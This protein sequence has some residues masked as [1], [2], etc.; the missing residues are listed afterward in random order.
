MDDGSETSQLY[1]VNLSAAPTFNPVQVDTAAMGGSIF[2]SVFTGTSDDGIGWLGQLDSTSS[3]TVE[4]AALSNLANVVSLD[5]S[6]PANT[7]EVDELY[8]SSDNR[9]LLIQGELDTAN[10]NELFVVDTDNPAA[11]VKVHPAIT[12]PKDVDGAAIE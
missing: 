7:T 8:L 12:A 6:L 3:V 10:V 2:G 11:P 4:W 9:R 5:G 1:Y